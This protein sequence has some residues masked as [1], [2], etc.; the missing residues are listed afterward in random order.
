MSKMFTPEQKHAPHKM[1]FTEQMKKLHDAIANNE[2]YL[3]R[4]YVYP[5]DDW[6]LEDYK[7]MFYYIDYGYLKQNGDDFPEGRDNHNAFTINE[8]WGD[9]EPLWKEGLNRVLGD[10]L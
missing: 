5:D 2:E 7:S 10:D 6:T 8:E 4:L 1:R 3:Y 9:R